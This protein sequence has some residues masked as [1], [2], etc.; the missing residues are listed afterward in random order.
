[1]DEWAVGIR[2]AVRLP[3]VVASL[4]GGPHNDE[5]LMMLLTWLPQ[6]AAADH[7]RGSI[8][9]YV[10][11]SEGLTC[12]VSCACE[13]APADHAFLMWSIAFAAR[14]RSAARRT[15]VTTGWADVEEAVAQHVAAQDFSLGILEGM[16][17]AAE[18]DL[19]PAQL[20]RAPRGSCAHTGAVSLTRESGSH[21]GRATRASMRG[22]LGASR[23]HSR[24]PARPVAAARAGRPH[25]RT[26]QG[27]DVATGRAHRGRSAP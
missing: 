5:C 10:V 18:R 14:R 23:P 15:W 26:G 12:E 20:R 22:A 13:G 9:E 21:R 4:P 16:A 17:R 19:G 2:A 1:M 24:H 8:L 7:Q 25:A 11:A 27:L 6:G 3:E